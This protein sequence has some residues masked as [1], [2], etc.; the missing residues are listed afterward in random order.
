M[1]FSLTITG[2]LSSTVGTTESYTADVM[3]GSTSV[4]TNVAATWAVGSGLSLPGSS[5][6]VSYDSVGTG[7]FVSASYT[8]AGEALSATIYVD[9]S[10][11]MTPIAITAAY[12]KNTSFYTDR[13]AGTSGRQLWVGDDTSKEYP[14]RMVVLLEG[15]SDVPYQAAIS[16]SDTGN[17]VTIVTSAPH[18]LT[19]GDY[20]SIEGAPTLQSWSEYYVATVVDAT[21]FTVPRDHSAHAALA[22]NDNVT[23]SKAF[24]KYDNPYFTYTSSDPTKIVL[25]ESVEGSFTFHVEAAAVAKAIGTTGASPSG[26]VTLSVTGKA[27][28]TISQVDL[29][30]AASTIAV[31]PNV[32]LLGVSPSVISYEIPHTGMPSSAVTRQL[33]VIARGLVSEG[34]LGDAQAVSPS[35]LT[36]S[37]ALTSIAT[38]SNA[39]LVTIVSK[40]EESV[41]VTH[42]ASGNTV[43]VPVVV[44]EEATPSTTLSHYLDVVTEFQKSL[45]TGLTS[46]EMSMAVHFS[47]GTY[48]FNYLLAAQNNFATE[49]TALLSAAATATSMNDLATTLG[50]DYGFVVNRLG[51]LYSDGQ[52]DADTFTYLTLDPQGIEAKATT[53][54]LGDISKDIGSG[55]TSAQF[56]S[57][58]ETKYGHS[59]KDVQLAGHVEGPVNSGLGVPSTFYNDQLEMIDR[60]VLNRSTDLLGPTPEMISGSFRGALLRSIGHLESL[61]NS[62]EIDTHLA[63]VRA[64]EVAGENRASFIAAIDAR[65]TSN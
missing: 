17:P 31:V 7:I 40:G 58:Y 56:W 5:G 48:S 43:R 15:I 20:V 52:L 36:Y 49:H 3:D 34:E 64:I 10:A 41:L 62:G 16:S 9:S 54:R 29:S 47:Q 57:A 1:P 26:D 60:G 11:D 8:H 4:A 65:F 19:T 44:T 14:H 6:S 37:T 33:S 2:P 55:A 18:N 32:E 24:Y 30:T 50:W 59:L 46:M 63:V 13:D 23:F 35:D 53:Q 38:V 39:G 51:Y 22:S 12:V 45:Y 21:S 25:S 61:L 28:Y 42:T 27:P